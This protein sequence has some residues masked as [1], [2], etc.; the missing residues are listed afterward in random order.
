MTSIRCN[1]A[2]SIRLFLLL[3]SGAIGAQPVNILKPGVKGVQ[4]PFASLKPSA[5]LKIGRTADWVLVTEDAV[6]VAGTKPYS[7]R[8]RLGEVLTGNER[9]IGHQG[10]VARSEDEPLAYTWKIRPDRQ[11]FETAR[12]KEL[13]LPRK[14]AQTFGAAAQFQRV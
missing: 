6:W 11:L 9:R 1:I 7:V 8:E 4:V 3:M 5:T 13:P 2:V 10:R 12:A 14:E